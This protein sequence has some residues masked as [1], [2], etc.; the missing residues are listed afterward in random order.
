LAETG[1]SESGAPATVTTASLPGQP[2]GDA[3]VAANAAAPVTSLPLSGSG[4]VHRFTVGTACDISAELL[5]HGSAAP[6]TLLDL[7]GHPYRVGAGGRFAFRIPVRDQALVMQ[8]LASVP[9]LPVE[10][11]VGESEPHRQDD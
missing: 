3:D 10:S 5:V 7:G 1:S 8:L 2:P 4:P 9:S 6:G 11:R